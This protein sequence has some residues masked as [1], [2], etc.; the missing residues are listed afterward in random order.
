MLCFPV[1]ILL[2]HSLQHK[3]EGTK[4][5]RAYTRHARLGVHGADL[6]I[7]IKIIN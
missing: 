7:K 6:D 3:L 2:S 5:K 1:N 4:E